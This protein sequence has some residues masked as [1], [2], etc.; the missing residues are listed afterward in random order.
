MTFRKQSAINNINEKSIVEEKVTRKFKLPKTTTNK[1]VN[2]NVEIKELSEE[3]NPK[4]NKTS[5][6]NKQKQNK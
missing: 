1:E 3:K 4:L 6:S 5:N 2:K